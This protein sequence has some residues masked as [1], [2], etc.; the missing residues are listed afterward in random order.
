MSEIFEEDIFQE[1]GLSSVSTEERVEFVKEFGRLLG[2]TSI[3]KAGDDLSEKDQDTLVRLFEQ[4]EEDRIQAFLTSR[5]IDLEAIAE[6][7]G[8]MIRAAVVTSGVEFSSVDELLMAVKAEFPP[9]VHA[10]ELTNVASLIH[11]LRAGLD[12]LQVDKEQTD[13]LVDMLIENA[14]NTAQME[15][16]ELLPPDIL[17]QVSELMD[18]DDTAGEGIQLM[19]KH[20]VDFVQ[21]NINEIRREFERLETEIKTVFD[22]LG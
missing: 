13:K 3:L 20:Q 14:S 19:L 9:N 12:S 18:G 21:I 6:I 1:V 11:E 7:E 22:G 17:A 2:I 16:E 15:V 4:Q 5:N 8:T 10:I